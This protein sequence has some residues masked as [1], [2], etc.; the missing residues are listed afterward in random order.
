MEQTIWAQC[1]ARLEGELS[2]QQFNTWIRPLHAVPDGSELTLLAPNHFVRDWVQQHFVN[3]IG[4]LMKDVGEFDQYH[5][6]V[7]VGS[8][9]PALS[10]LLQCLRLPNQ[11]PPERRAAVPRP[12]DWL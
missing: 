10:E 12:K 5:V 9:L 1:L 4:E 11:R 7:P 8:R 2:P 3:R 6:I